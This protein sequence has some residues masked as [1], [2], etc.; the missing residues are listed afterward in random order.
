M[1]DDDDPSSAAAGV[2]ASISVV[3][4]T[5]RTNQFLNGAFTNKMTGTERHALRSTYTLPQN[6][7][8][9][10]P[11]LD[12]MMA[13]QCSRTVKSTNRSLYTLQGL[14]LEAIGPLNQFMEAINDPDPQVAINNSDPQVTMDQ[15]GE[16]VE[17]AVTSLAN[18]S[19][20]MSLM[21]R[22]KILEEYN[23]EFVPF[24]AAKEQDW[25]ST[26]PRLF[27]PNF[28]KEAADYLQQLQLVRKVK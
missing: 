19:N 18:A 20:K 26:V 24:A 10:A 1:L 3:P 17:T 8:T 5:D 11:F 14:L 16:A 12:T 25:A 22:T 6:K 23:K 21:R 7:L 28:L 4:V 15:I 27:G 9:R 13:S 2:S